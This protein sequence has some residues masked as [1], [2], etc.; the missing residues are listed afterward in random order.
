MHTL[1]SLG[2]VSA[3]IVLAVLLLSINLYSRWSWPVK[4]GTII[5]TA[6]FYFVTFM[7]VPGLLGWPVASRLPDKFRLL[8]AEVQQ[9]NKLT[10]DKGAIY[11]WITDANDLAADGPPRSYK[12]P[13]SEPTYQAILNATAKL[14]NGVAQLGEQ[15]L[16]GAG[17]GQR[18]IKYTRGGQV[19]ERLK[20][21]DMPK[22]ALPDK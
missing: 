13:Y 21:Y 3:Y 8:A 19:S 5:I 18:L 16:N 2:L 15:K 10:H 4:A 22:P 7:S 9:P 11:L 6:A 17:K 1:S 12:L 14:R 20:F